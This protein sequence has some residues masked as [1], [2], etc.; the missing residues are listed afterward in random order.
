MRKGLIWAVA[1]CLVFIGACVT[2]NIYFPAAA[3]QKAADKIIEDIQGKEQKPE[4]A[5]APQQTPDQKPVQGSGLF[6]ELKGVSFGPATAYAAEDL[7]IST[8]AIL[9]I[10]ES[11]KNRYQ[12]L[13]PYFESGVL[14]FGNN[15]QIAVRDAS[16]LP[17]KDKATLNSLVSQQN[18]DWLSLYQEIAKANNLGGDAVPR[19]QKTFA[20]RLRAKA[21]PGRWIQ[22]DTGAWVKK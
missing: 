19:F 4:Q 6:N 15:G 2:V 5:P 12:Q 13:K 8:P 18:K 14:G 20:E 9:A 10:K 7:D 16:S 17:L 22:T 21:E 11:L 3:A 1:I